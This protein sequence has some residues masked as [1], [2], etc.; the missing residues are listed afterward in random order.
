MKRH[1]LLLLGILSVGIHAADNAGAFIEKGVSAR[2][3]GLAQSY[4]AIAKASDATYWNPAALYKLEQAELA[5]QGADA[6]DTQTIAVQ[7][8]FTYKEIPIGLQYIGASIDGFEETVADE[9][10]AG[11]FEKTGKTY[12]YRAD[13][14][15]IGTGKK[16]R[17][18]LA[19]GATGKILREEAAGYKAVGVG[20]DM[21]I[22]SEPTPAVALGLLFQNI[23]QPQMKWDTPAKSVDTVPRR[24]KLGARYD[25]IPNQWTL[26]SDLVAQ[27]NR[28]LR[29]NIGTEVW[30]ANL[31][32]IRGG[33]QD[34]TLSLGT[35]IRYGGI[36]ADIAWVNP[37]LDEMDEVYKFSIGL[38]LGKLKPLRKGR[39]NETPKK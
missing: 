28:P 14:L 20:L 6:Y 4:T 5:I 34:K 13:A 38:A 39:A 17:P 32:A 18:N 30:I 29:F 12:D 9:D 24:I 3:A 15:Y 23:I 10:R 16:M 27:N 19:L 36:R 1:I 2:A 37:D 7:G 11:F 33:F 31:V 25:M 8:A 35:G 21:G 22:L 26:S